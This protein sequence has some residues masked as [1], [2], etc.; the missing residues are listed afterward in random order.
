MKIS[1]IFPGQGSQFVGMGKDFYDSFNTAKDVYSE[2][3]NTLNRPLSEIIFSGS[4]DELRNTINSQPSIMATSI[5]IYNTIM[6]EG[7]IDKNLIKCVA[8]HSLGEYSSLVVNE[9]LSVEDSVKLLDIRSKAMQESMPIGT[10]GMVALIG[11]TLIEVEEILPE[12]QKIGKIFIANDNADG[13]VVLSGEIRVIKYI[14]ENYKKF[15]IKRA[16][17]LPVS[18]PFHCELIQSASIKLKNEIA[19]QKFNNFI[20]PLYSNVTAEPCDN[21][22]VKDLLVRQIINRV[23]WKESVENMIRD[24]VDYFIEIGPGNVL[25]NLLKRINK[26]VRAISVGTVED[27]KKLN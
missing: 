18:A 3:D 17:Q 23:R 9:S 12:I 4:E 19:G 20:F 8:G 11:K 16:V 14:C 25:T 21:E 13:Q 26:E 15:K 24:G 6:K 7:L 1:L 10:G 22:T 27:L 2:L 5:A